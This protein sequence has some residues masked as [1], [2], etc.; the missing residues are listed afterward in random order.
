MVASEGRARYAAGVFREHESLRGQ[1]RQFTQV[2]V[3]LIGEGGAMGDAEVVSL[4]V[5]ALDAA[6]VPDFTVAIGT[7]AVL[8]ALVAAAGESAAWG[9][10][11]LAA[12]HDRNVVGLDALAAQAGGA[13]GRRFACP[14]AGGA[15]GRAPGHCRAG[16]QAALD[17]LPPHKLMG[18]RAASGHR[19]FGHTIVCLPARCRRGV[20]PGVGLLG[21]GGR[22]D[23]V[24][25]PTSVCRLRL[26]RWA[27]RS[28][29]WWAG[30][31]VAIRADAIV[32]GRPARRPPAAVKLAD[33]AVSPASFGREAGAS[34]QPGAAGTRRAQCG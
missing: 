25:P 22:Y 17:S 14:D 32:S 18:V 4:L 7:V 31:H 8:N 15:G 20:R 11:V 24:S 5:A 23:G 28:V 9:E 26:T 29:R 12:A 34:A 3:E 13:V 16:L 10:A 2:G 21:G 19:D 30:A 6:G 33:V 1:S 27:Q